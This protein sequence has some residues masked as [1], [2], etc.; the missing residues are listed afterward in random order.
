MFRGFPVPALLATSLLLIVGCSSRDRA[1]ASRS[2]DLV[3]LGGTLVTLDDAHPEAEALAARDG[4]IV[5]LGSRTEIEPWIGDRTEVLE[6]APGELAIPGFI[7]SHGH[8]VGIGDAAIQLDLGGAA[9]WQAI[10]EQV[11]AAVEQAPAGQWIRGRGWHQEKWQVPPSPAVEGFPVHDT[12][13]AISPENPVI[14]THASGH[15]VF[16]NAKAMELGGIDSETLDPPGGEILH[17]P[18]GQPTGLLRE[19]A[20]GLV[21]HARL[22]DG[23]PPADELRRMI[24]LASDDVVA[25]GITSFD[26]AGSSF[27][28]V[29]ALAAASDDGLLAPRL[30]V[31]IRAPNDD[32]RA[33]LASYKGQRDRAGRVIVGGIKLSIDG[34]LGSRG[35][36]ML[37]PYADAPGQR[38]LNLIPVAEARETAEIA[39]DEGVQ[40]CIHAI[41]DRANRE[42]LDLYQATFEA[43]HDKKDLRWRI[44]HAQ[45]LN[46]DDIPRF[47]ELGVIASMQGI[48]CTSDGPWVPERIGDQR[49][50]EGAYVW[51]KLA[52]SGALIINGTDAPV[53]SVSPIASF[54][55]SIS[56]RLA[57]GSRFY[58]DQRMGREEALRTYTRNAAYGVFQEADKGNL[59]VGKL[60]DITVLSKNILTVDEDAVADTEVRYTIIGGKVAYRGGRS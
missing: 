50:E 18:D 25:H 46:P 51:R 5:A 23:M 27:A 16:V 56:R 10:V 30:W 11:A 48:H 38:G 4:R 8:F 42:V 53:E 6:L 32:L 22:A 3:L 19:S 35:A 41:G 17:A 1:S 29:D 52:D 49:A 20:A 21:Q 60:A 59:E 45:H 2:A 24:K 31:M 12:L 13:S 57:D 47:A 7:E 58:P 43:H 55:A 33:R 54:Y 15:A 9:S 39:I 26:D 37:A 40:L 44:E 34:A 36:W 14:L 28:V